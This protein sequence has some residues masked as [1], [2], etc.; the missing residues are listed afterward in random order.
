MEI[1][2]THAVSS[3]SSSSN[4]HSYDLDNNNNQKKII[5]S[6][7][8]NLRNVGEINQPQLSNIQLKKINSIL[9][10]YNI[11]SEQ[12]QKNEELSEHQKKNRK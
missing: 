12:S 4:N 5:N 10:K 7:K 2:N 9:N 6:K 1:H 3:Y 11:A 8:L